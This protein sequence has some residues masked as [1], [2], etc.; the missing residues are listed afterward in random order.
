MTE[1]KKPE[2]K[3]AAATQRF[4]DVAKELGIEV[5]AAA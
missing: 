5:K 4:S 3:K 1:K 2:A